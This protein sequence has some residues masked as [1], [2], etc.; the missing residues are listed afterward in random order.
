MLSDQYRPPSSSMTLAWNLPGGYHVASL[1]MRRHIQHKP[2]DVY[3]T[4]EVMEEL[5]PGKSFLI[6]SGQSGHGDT[7]EEAIAAAKAKVDVSLESTRKKRIEYWK[8]PPVE[9]GLTSEKP[10]PDISGLKLDLDLGL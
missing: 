9:K 4:Y 8:N 1:Q 6:S 7:L 10:G 3:L 2:F 5:V